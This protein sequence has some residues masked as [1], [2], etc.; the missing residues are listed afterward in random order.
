MPI[1]EKGEGAEQ[2]P[3]RRFCGKS[4]ANGPGARGA[5]TSTCQHVS[6]ANTALTAQ[7]GKAG[8]WASPVQEGLQ[9]AG[10]AEREQGKPVVVLTCAGNGCSLVLL[11]SGGF[12]SPT[13]RYGF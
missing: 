5:P 7:R 12:A 3:E 2:E 9:E 11:S 8:T 13:G 4:L 1:G 10:C 6:R